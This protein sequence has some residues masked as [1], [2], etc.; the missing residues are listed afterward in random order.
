MFKN[1]LIRCRR[2]ST[3]H[4][5]N[6]ASENENAKSYCKLYHLLLRLLSCECIWAFAELGM[7]RRLLVV[8]L[9]GLGGSGG[10]SSM[11]VRSGVGGLLTPELW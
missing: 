5:L 8:E 7:E 11:D 4:F 10:S 1:P 6:F 9:E 2:K 3:S